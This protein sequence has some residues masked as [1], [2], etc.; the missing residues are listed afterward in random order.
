MCVNT[1]FFF[2]IEIGIVCPVQ[3]KTNQLLVNTCVGRKG[4]PN[5]FFVLLVLWFFGKL[6]CIFFG[7]N[8]LLISELVLVIILRNKFRILLSVREDENHEQNK[9]DKRSKC[10][11]NTMSPVNFL[12]HNFLEL[13]FEWPFKVSVKRIQQFS[14][15]VVHSYFYILFRHFNFL[16]RKRK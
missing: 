4:Y 10:Y 6:I 2:Y 3:F 15:L 16:F 14:F 9:C 11:G 7:I 13:N 5:S 8:Y 12:Q 1:N